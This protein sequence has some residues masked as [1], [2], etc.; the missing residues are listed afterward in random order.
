MRNLMNM[1]RTTKGKK[2]KLNKLI[3][4][5]NYSVIY[6]IKQTIFGY[7]IMLLT[8]MEEKNYK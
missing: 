8:S 7:K 5:T 4:A 3:I 6:I 2:K 1:R